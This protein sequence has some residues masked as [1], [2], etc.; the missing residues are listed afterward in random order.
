MIRAGI[1]GATGYTGLEILKILIRHPFCNVTRLAAKPLDKP[2]PIADIF[3]NLNGICSIVCQNDTDVD[4][5]SKA[6]DVVFLAL[7]HTVSMTY[8]GKFLK[9]GLKVIDLSADFRFPDPDTYKS[10]YGATHK[11]EELLKKAVY[12]LPELNKDKIKQ[13]KLIA[14][15]GCYPTSVLLGLLPLLSNR[16]IDSAKPIIMDCKSG[17]SGAG[18][19]PF[20]AAHFPECNESIKA[21]KILCHPHIGEIENIIGEVLASK[22]ECLF[23]PHLIPISRGILSTLYAGLNELISLDKIL[24]AYRDFY[25][26]APFVRVLDKGIFPEVRYVAHTNFCDIGIAVKDKTAIIVTAIDNLVKGAAGQAVEN[27][28]IMFGRDEREGLI[29]C[30]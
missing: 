9:K 15:P 28:N 20:L 29:Q 21:Y 3:P 17:V 25:K 7:P 10:W 2:T 26:A 6:C 4:A 19:N 12:G 30:Q 5:V 27:M 22:P 13:A 11:S 8:A 23:V 16:S 1:I 24:S 18:R 14:N